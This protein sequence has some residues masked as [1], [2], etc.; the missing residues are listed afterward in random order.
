MSLTASELLIDGP[1]ARMMLVGAERLQYQ[2][3][4]VECERRSLGR[5]GQGVFSGNRRQGDHGG[6]LGS[7]RVSRGP[8]TFSSSGCSLQKINFPV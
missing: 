2:T 6:L 5:G 4:L 1:E 8:Q 3:P 7:V